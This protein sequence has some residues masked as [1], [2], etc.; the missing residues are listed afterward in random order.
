MADPVVQQMLYAMKAQRISGVK[1]CRL[2][3]YD[4]RI[5]SDLKRGIRSP[6]LRTL[7]DMGAVLGLELCWRPHVPV[8]DRVDRHDG[9]QSTDGAL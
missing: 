3:G 8:V 1:L 6:H 4:R 5:M 9:Q 7:L 2:A